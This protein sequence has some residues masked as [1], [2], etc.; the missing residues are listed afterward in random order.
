[1]VR[2][3]DRRRAQIAAMADPDRLELLAFILGSASPAP[4][5]MVIASP[6]T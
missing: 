1:M 5:A 6:L 2:Y 3:D 4:A